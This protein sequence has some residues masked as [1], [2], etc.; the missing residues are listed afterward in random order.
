MSADEY[1]VNRRP[2][3]TAI[4]NV[5][6]LIALSI[7]VMFQIGLGQTECAAYAQSG[8]C[9][10]ADDVDIAGNTIL[11]GELQVESTPTAGAAGEVLLSQGTTNPPQWTDYFVEVLKANDET[12]VASTTLQNDDDFSFTVVAN[13]TYIVEFGFRLSENIAGGQDFKFN[14]TGPSGAIWCSQAGDS[15][16]ITDNEC[17]TNDLNIDTGDVTE[18][19]SP[20]LVIV[21]VA[22]TPGTIQLQ[23]AQVVATNNTTLHQFSTMRVKRIS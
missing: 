16:G 15:T 12:V 11:R 6:L 4:T 10:A 3:L 7:L 5:A 9:T 1:T 13:A 18:S 20:A 22:G 19:L 21:D 14:F 23:W 2:S 8:V 17:G